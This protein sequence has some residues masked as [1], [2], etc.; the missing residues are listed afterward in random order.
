MLDRWLGQRF[1]RRH[2]GSGEMGLTGAC[3]NQATWRVLAAANRVRK[4][5]VVLPGPVGPTLKIAPRLAPTTT[6]IIEVLRSSDVPLTIPDVSRR[7]EQTL[8]R[9]VSRASVKAALSD[10]A[11]AQKSPVRRV[12]RGRYESTS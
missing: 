12:S 11:A 9:C 4:D 10:M 1:E 3:S 8:G 2:S 7:V 5:L 6:A